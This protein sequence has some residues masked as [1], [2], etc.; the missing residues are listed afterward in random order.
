VAAR[1]GIVRSTRPNRLGGNVVWLRDDLGRG[2]YY[3]HLE[4]HAV[5]RGQAVRAGDTIG[6]VGNSG[7]ARTTPPHLHFG[8]YQRGSFDPY[9]A[10][11]PLAGGPQPFLGAADMI[12]AAVRANRAGTRVV[13][14]PDGRAA[15]V[16][17]VSRHT[18]LHVEGGAGPWYRVRLPDGIRGFVAIDDIESADGPVERRVLARGGGVYLDP[19]GIGVAVDSV[20]AGS[21][22]TVLGAFGEALYVQGPSGR[23]GWVTA[24]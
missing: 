12:G 11:R 3:A 5:R 10:L 7:N 24:N 15:V 14:R 1:D 16:A 2:L 22:V 20:P 21:E 6:F 13:D 17:E 4:R 8:V 18:L 9:P 23:L 19:A